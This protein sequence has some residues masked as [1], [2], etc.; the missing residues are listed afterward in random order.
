MA[1]KVPCHFGV[2]SYFYVKDMALESTSN[3]IS[4][5]SYIFGIAPVALQAIN[6][7][8]VGRCHSWWCCRFL[9]MYVSY[10]P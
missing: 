10:M 9:V 4:N 5:L 6:E 8:T 2:G 1:S 7:I 3:F